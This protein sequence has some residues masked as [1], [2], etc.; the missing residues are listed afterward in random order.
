MFCADAGPEIL[1]LL[2]VGGILALRSGA[3]IAEIRNT[4]RN[5]PDAPSSQVDYSSYSDALLSISAT[6]ARWLSGHTERIMITQLVNLSEAADTLCA[7]FGRRFPASRAGGERRLA[8]F[9][10]ERFDLS[11][12]GARQV[13]AKLARHQAIYWI[14]EPS[15]SRPCPGIL[16]L[17][18]D[19]II[20]PEC[21]A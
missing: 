11:E 13:L 7:H 16:E 6:S 8:V 5:S 17:C 2:D 19:W 18:G 1:A 10:C 20:R 21:F 3:V 4:L 12:Q 9:L 15:L 14:A